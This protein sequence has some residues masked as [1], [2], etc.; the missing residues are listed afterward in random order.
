VVSGTAL[1]K[2]DWGQV[3]I[4][5]RKGFEMSPPLRTT[6]LEISLEEDGRAIVLK[7][8]L[9][10]STA[11]LLSEPLSDAIASGAGSIVVDLTDCT[12]IDSSGLEALALASWNLAATNGDRPVGP[13]LLVA[14]PPGEVRRILDLTGIDHILIVCE[15]RAQALAMLGERSAY[16]AH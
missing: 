6:L 5:Y 13:K 4:R 11:D 16:L 8:E 14:C 7:G 10:L 3:H 1:G 15:T 12:F 9:C 2:P